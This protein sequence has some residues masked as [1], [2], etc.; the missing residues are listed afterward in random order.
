MRFVNSGGVSVGTDPYDMQ[1]VQYF[2]PSGFFDLPPLPM[3]G[4][5][6]RNVGDT[7][8]SNKCIYIKQSLPLPMTL[9]ALQYN[10]EFSV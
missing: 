5:E 4:D 10:I 7:A 2:N 1:E 8:D 6:S 9:T 3:D